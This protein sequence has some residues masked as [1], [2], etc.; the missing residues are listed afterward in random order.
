[1]LK[2]DQSFIRMIGNDS[3]S[4]H[5]VEN[6]LDLA[7]RLGMKTVAEGVETLEQVEYLAQH[8]VHCLQG[9]YFAKP[10]PIKEFIDSISKQS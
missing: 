10:M 1:M 3:V 2:I 5:I 4:A 6:L 7:S 9:Y 8:K